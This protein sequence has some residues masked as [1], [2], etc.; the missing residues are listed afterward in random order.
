MMTPAEKANLVRKLEHKKLEAKRIKQKA[1][2]QQASEDS[3]KELMSKALN[4]FNSEISTFSVCVEKRHVSIIKDILKEN[5]FTKENGWKI[6][7]ETTKDDPYSKYISTT[8][9]YVFA[10]VILPT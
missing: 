4:E 10:E 3:A 5:G 6:Y 9:T 8:T 1:E 2:D 7:S